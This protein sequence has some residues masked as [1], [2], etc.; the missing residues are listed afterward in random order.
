MMVIHTCYKYIYVLLHATDRQARIA[1][2]AVADQLI[3]SISS[4]PSRGGTCMSDSKTW[5]HHG[6]T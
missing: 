1:N 2:L 4:R 3:L 6:S 5:Q